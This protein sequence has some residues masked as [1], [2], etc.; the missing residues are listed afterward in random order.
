MLGVVVNIYFNK[1]QWGTGKKSLEKSFLISV[2]PFITYN[3]IQEVT[4]TMIFTHPPAWV[5]YTRSPNPFL[6]TMPPTCELVVLMW[7]IGDKLHTIPT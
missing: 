5:A 3:S 6:A 4:T 2:I 7:S 1:T